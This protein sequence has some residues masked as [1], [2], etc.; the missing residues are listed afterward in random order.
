MSLIALTLPQGYVNVAL[1]LDVE[2]PTP[3]YGQHAHS[4]G[5]QFCA[6]AVP[7][8]YNEPCDLRQPKGHIISSSFS[9]S[10]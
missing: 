10:T 1:S 4:P 2:G 5:S 8:K 9:P 3:E 6:C 7:R